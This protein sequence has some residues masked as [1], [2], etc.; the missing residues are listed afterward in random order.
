M[1]KLTI[2]CYA[3][4]DIF[5]NYLPHVSILLNKYSS[6]F[7]IL[8]SIR[9]ESRFNFKSINGPNDISILIMR[10]LEASRESQIEWFLRMTKDIV[11]NTNQYIL[12]IIFSDMN[13][14]II[15]R[16]ILSYQQQIRNSTIK[17]F[18]FEDWFPE[19]N[20]SNN[21]NHHYNELPLFNSTIENYLSSLIK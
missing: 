21:F 3:Q 11:N 8:P 6:H 2:C 12:I 14:E 5:N 4:Y 18:D 1:D 15:D 10:E 7:D 16:R 19:D 9:L 20:P 17:Y 13:L